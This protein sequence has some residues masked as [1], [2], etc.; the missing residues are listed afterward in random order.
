[1][2][3]VGQ[4]LRDSYRHA[5]SVSGS[6]ILAACLL[7]GSSEVAAEQIG[8]ATRIVSDVFGNTLNRTLI[9]GEAL[10]AGQKVRTGLYGAADLTFHDGSIL[11]MGPRS[12]VTLDAFAFDPAANIVRG[13][14]QAARGLMRFASGS[15]K[16]N[17]VVKAGAA[18]LHVR[19][20]SFDFL[21][22]RTSTEIVVR[23]GTVEVTSKDSSRTL[24]KD[25][26][27][28]V[29]D[30]S[31]VHRQSAASKEMEIELN[32]T[33]KL[34]G[35]TSKQHLAEWLAKRRQDEGGV[36]ESD[37]G[38]VAS[39][40]PRASPGTNTGAVNQPTGSPPLHGP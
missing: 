29:S 35:T 3:N 33:F 2:I 34:L 11:V 31:G 15:A 22:K 25:Q 10:Y 17:L 40:A 18:I 28:S 12:E 39:V 16:L 5:L 8:A 27:L 32:Q 37:P 9:P 7:V 1:M 14:I 21:V 26:V 20:T 36:K 23:E 19:G 6:G 13:N 4:R 30:R 24:E 38:S